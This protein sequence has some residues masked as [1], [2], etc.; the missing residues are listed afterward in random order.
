MSIPSII[1]PIDMN[2][3]CDVA[4]RAGLEILD[5]YHST[6]DVAV[7]VKADNS[8]L[9]EA[10]R[11]SNALILEA[12]QIICP[13]VPVISEESAQVPYDDR[14]QWPLF[15]LIDPLDGTKEF[16]RRNGEFTVNI[17]LVAHGTPVAGIVHQPTTGNTYWTAGDNASYLRQSDGT[18]TLLRKGA[19]YETLDHVRVVG[20]RSHNTPEVTAFVEKLQAQGRSVEFTP[21][22]SSLKMCLV[23][24]GLADVYPRFGPTMEWD[25]AAA[26]AVASHAG[27]QVLALPKL[28]PLR[29]NKPSLLNPHFIVR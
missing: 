28:T 16:L 29:Y 4:I 17:A 12:L 27:C 21:A 10:D 24:Q 1:P 15:W 7:E 20:S 2:W 23:A 6:N 13:D 19:D 18:D 5:V 22:G 9:T 11:R 26:H 3:L 25:T 14:R 8:P